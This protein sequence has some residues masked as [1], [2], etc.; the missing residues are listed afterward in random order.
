[1]DRYITLIV[2]RESWILVNLDGS[3]RVAI[4]SLAHNFHAL[5]LLISSYT[6]Y[7]D[8][9]EATSWETYRHLHPTMQTA[10]IMQTS[11]IPTMLDTTDIPNHTVEVAPSMT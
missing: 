2:E 10:I 8:N 3:K 5:F 11:A 4:R 7:F 1:M 6:H 9:Q